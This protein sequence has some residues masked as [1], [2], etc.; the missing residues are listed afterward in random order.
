MDTDKN[1]TAEITEIAENITTEDIENKEGLTTGKHRYYAKRP[2]TK[3][4]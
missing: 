3:R 1:L 2:P 4:R